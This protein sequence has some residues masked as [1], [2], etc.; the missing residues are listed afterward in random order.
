MSLSYSQLAQPQ[1]AIRRK[2]LAASRLAK[3]ARA[4]NGTYLPRAFFLT[5]PDRTKNLLGVIANLPRGFGVIYR[6]Y[7]AA[8]RY[9]VGAALARACRRRGLI[10]LVSADPALAVR[11]GANGVHW[12]EARLTGIRPRHPRFIETAAAHSR[13][14]IARTRRLGV[15]AAVV[16]TVFP[17]RSPSAGKALGPLRFRLIAR[18]AGIPVYA[19]GGINAQTASCAMSH[20][21]GWAA[22]DAVMDAWEN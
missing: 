7:G 12:P 20:A 5:D 4:R 19:L 15:D 9:V 10:L 18:S 22:I 1:A 21:A 14:A 16:S 17:S 3:P 8:N 11:I 13:A 6:H 2:L